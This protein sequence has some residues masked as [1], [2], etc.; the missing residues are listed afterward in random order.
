MYMWILYIQSE[1]HCTPVHLNIHLLHTQSEFFED[2]Y[3]RIGTC[4]HIRMYY[5]HSLRFLQTVC[6]SL[7]TCTLEHRFAL[8][9]V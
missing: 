1:H 7:K 2:V 3:I 5:T 4:V 6:T 9:T 8:H